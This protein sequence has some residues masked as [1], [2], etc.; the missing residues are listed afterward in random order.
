MAQPLTDAIN[1]LTRYAN[2]TTG[3]SDQTLSDAVR[4]L[5]DG[6]GGGGG[7]APS[8][9]H[10]FSVTPTEDTAEV[11]VSADFGSYAPNMFA[12]NAD[13]ELIRPTGSTLGALSGSISYIT[14][15]SSTVTA[16]QG[17]DN[18]TDTINASGAT[19]WWG[20]TLRVTATTSTAKFELY[21][22][23]RPFRFLAGQKYIF[24]VIENLD[25]YY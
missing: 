13:G 21:R 25:T 6:Y 15:R 19:D 5:C 23:D 4:T 17:A 3:A 10:V 2:E 24:V 14:N 12:F 8:F 20:R 7:D 18:H 11:T 22:T 16:T 9:V 1:A